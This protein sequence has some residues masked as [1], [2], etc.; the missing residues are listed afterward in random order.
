MVY[1]ML[2]ELGFYFYFFIFFRIGVLNQ[3]SWI[4][5]STYNLGD[6]ICE[7]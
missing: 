6:V 3:P 5:A 2:S 7:C 1:T 4:A